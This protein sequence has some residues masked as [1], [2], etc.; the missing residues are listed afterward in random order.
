MNLFGKASFRPEAN[1]LIAVVLMIAAVFVSAVGEVVIAVVLVVSAAVLSIG[2]LFWNAHRQDKEEL[3][4]YR[5]A[6]DARASA[7]GS[8]AEASKEEQ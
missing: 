4:A 5:K 8:Q 1:Q 7:A 2:S 3:V 6:K